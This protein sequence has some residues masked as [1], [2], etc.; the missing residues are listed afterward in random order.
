MTTGENTGVK[1]MEVT[2]DFLIGPEACSRRVDSYSVLKI[3]QKAQ[4]GRS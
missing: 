4:L 1:V 3:W 2:N